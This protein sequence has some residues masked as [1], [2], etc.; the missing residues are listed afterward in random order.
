MNFVLLFVIFVIMLTVV[1]RDLRREKNK[2][3]EGFDRAV[4]RAFFS[5]EE[6]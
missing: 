6:L 1:I 2:K 3:K 5:K 4:E